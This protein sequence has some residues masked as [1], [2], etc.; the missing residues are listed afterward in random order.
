MKENQKS[1]ALLA[2]FSETQRR[3]LKPFAAVHHHV[4]KQ[5]I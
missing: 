3:P 2:I 1:H 4:I 5:N